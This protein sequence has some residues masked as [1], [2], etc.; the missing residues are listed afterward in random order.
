MN[1]T[2]LD[3]VL[4]TLKYMNRIIQISATTN[5]E[6]KAVV[7]GLD[8]QGN[9]YVLTKRTKKWEFVTNSLPIYA[10]TGNKE[11]NS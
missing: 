9:L 8:E 3:G 10:N 4:G 5:N 11:N 2:A 1:F 7:F 6:N